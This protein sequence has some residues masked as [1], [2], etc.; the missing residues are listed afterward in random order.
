MKFKIKALSYLFMVAI[1]QSCSTSENKQVVDNSH[2][3][4]QMIEL[5]TN[6]QNDIFP[7]ALNPVSN[8]LVVF[9]NSKS[10]PSCIIDVKSYVDVMNRNYNVNAKFYTNKDGRNLNGIDK[11]I[12][13]LKIIETDKIFSELSFP[14]IFETDASGHIVNCNV[15]NSSYMYL[16]YNYIKKYASMHP[17]DKQTQSVKN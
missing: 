14:L 6:C 15:I 17:R 1:I 16:S 7:S 11:V 4:L 12:P 10:C 5:S 8:Q 9:F 3:V 2:D 13:S